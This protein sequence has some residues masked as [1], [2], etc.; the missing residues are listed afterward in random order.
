[1]D[2]VVVDENVAVDEQPSGTLVY[3][4]KKVRIFYKDI[5]QSG[6]IFDV[7]N[8]TGVNVTIQADSVSVNKRSVND[9]MMSDDVAPHSVGEV[10]ASCS[11]EYEG[12]VTTI[13]GQL[14]V[15]DFGKSFNTYKASFTNV[16]VE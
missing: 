4:D 10:I 11:P 12:G 13:G 8:L 7:E 2:N 15:I 5:N 6:V 3:E 9:I 1:M 14:R 16:P